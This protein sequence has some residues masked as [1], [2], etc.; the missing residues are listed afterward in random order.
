MTDAELR[1][2]RVTGVW[3][4]YGAFPYD[5]SAM[6]LTNGPTDLIK[7]DV[8]FYYERYRFDTVSEN[9][10]FD[11]NKLTVLLTNSP[12]SLGHWVFLQHRQMSPDM[13]SK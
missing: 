3:Q 7:V 5:M 9:I 6:N 11:A 13:A 12:M 1:L 10:S 8:K 2:N 4:M